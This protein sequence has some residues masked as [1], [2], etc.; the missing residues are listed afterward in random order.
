MPSGLKKAI[1]RGLVR[2][3]VDS[4]WLH[5]WG[6]HRMPE[7]SFF[8]EGRQFHVCA[9]CTGILC[10]APLGLMALPFHESMPQLFAFFFAL[11]AVDGLTQLWEWRSSNNVLRFMSGIGFT[12]TGIPSIFHLGSVISG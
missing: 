3:F 10:G 12:V 6:C 1:N 8:V 4:G 9:R 2:L 5:R 11:M 7:R